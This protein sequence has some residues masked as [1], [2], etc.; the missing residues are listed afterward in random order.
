VKRLALIALIALL[1]VEVFAQET[2]FRK[3]NLA[4]AGSGTQSEVDA[5]D[6]DILVAGIGG[7]GVISGC[8][9]QAQGSPDM[10]LAVGSGTVRIGTTIV[11]VSS[12]NVTITTAHATLERIDL[13]V[14]NSSGTKSVTAGTASANPAYPA[15]PANSIV[16]AD[17]TI[18]AGDTSIS[19]SQIYGKQILLGFTGQLATLTAGR[20]A[21]VG[22]G[23]L[24]TDDLDL[25]FATDTTLMTKAV[26]GTAAGAVNSISAQET[27]D[28]LTFEGTTDDAFELRICGGA[29]TSDK[30]F[31]MT[32][33]DF[34]FSEDIFVTGHVSVTTYFSNATAGTTGGI[35][36]PTS[37]SYTPDGPTLA[38]GSTSNSWHVTGN[39]DSGSD[40]GNGPGGT[41]VLGAG[42]G[43]I[44][45]APGSSQTS[46]TTV[47]SNAISSQRRKTL[48][49]AGGAEVIFQITTGTTAS[50]G[51]EIDYKVFVTDGTDYATRAGKVRFVFNNRA[52]TVTATLSGADETADSSVIDASAG[53]TLTYA[54][55]ADVGTA[56]VF[57][58][59]INIDSNITSN[60]AHMDYLVTY[61]GPGEVV[62]Q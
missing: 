8:S 14:V 17:V 3:P 61:N 45:H 39:A 9:V 52:G 31:K 47:Q 42:C 27:A 35:F 41:S 28:C 36:Y 54:I 48:T 40:L 20:V 22:T 59:A 44:F 43:A 62:P 4:D 34:D 49:E 57:K 2:V 56:N 11:A 13:V 37:A 55:T 10:T 51:G 53:E 6:F 15:I 21:L 38:C 12:G 32:S 30:T 46:Y 5:K 58:L 16:L 18:P 29:M 25:T 60:A 24:L 26:F 23:G 50:G 1:P 19:N 7:S 33:D